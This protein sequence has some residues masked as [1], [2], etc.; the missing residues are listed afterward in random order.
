MSAQNTLLFIAALVCFCTELEAFDQNERSSSAQATSQQAIDA[1]KKCH[2]AS[3]TGHFQQAFPLCQG[4]L[5]LALSAFGPEHPNTISALAELAELYH[6][7]GLYAEAEP[8]YKQALQVREKTLGSEHP[9]VATSLNSL[10]LL[11]NHQRRYEQAEPLIQRALAIRQKALGAEHPDVAAILNNLASLDHDRGLYAEAETLYA[12]ALLIQQQEK[13]V[14]NPLKATILNNLASLYYDQGRYAEAEALY[15]QALTIELKARGELHPNVA[16]GMNYLA[17]VYLAQGRYAQA[18]LF[19]KGALSTWESAMGKEHRNVAGALG[20]LAMLYRHRGQYSEAEPLFKRAI[21]IHEHVLGVDHPSLATSLD[22]LAGLYADQRRFAQAYQLASRA[23]GIRRKTL[24]SEHPDVAASLNNL[25]SIYHDQ[26]QYVQAEQLLTQALLIA[27]KA[28]GT[29]HPQVARTL[30]NVALLDLAQKRFPQALPY[31]LR[32]HQIWEKLIRHTVSEPRVTA[33][34]DQQREEEERLYGL[35]LEHGQDTGL[36][37]LA[38]TLILLRKGRAAEAGAQASRVILDTLST[39]QQHV[40]FQQWQRLRSEH[41][42]L[43]FLGS[44]LHASTSSGDRLN[45]LAMQIDELEHEL[46]AASPRARSLEV[47]NW[48]NALSAVAK[49]LPEASVL[50]EVVLAH[51][52]NFQ[53]MGSAQRWG[54]A[55]YIAM[56]LFPDRRMDTV[57]IGEEEAIDSRVAAFLRQLGDKSP[58]PTSAAQALYQQVM[59]PLQTKL[60]KVK[61]LYLSLDGSLNLIPFSAL[62]DGSQYLID[63][64]QIHYLTSGRDLLWKPLG[65]SGVPLVLADPDYG[66]EVK[67]GAPPRNR[68]IEGP[69]PD[70]YAQLRELRR[71]P[72]TRKEAKAIALLLPEADVRLDAAASE[73]SLRQAQA[74]RILHIATHGLFLADA[75]QDAQ[76][77]NMLSAETR[78]LVPLRS[79]LFSSTIPNANVRMRANRL[80]NPLSRSALI[81]A[82]ATHAER[83]LDSQHDGVLTA[84]EIRSMNLWGT[85]LVVLSACETGRGA[86]KTGQGVYGLR[87]SFFVAGAQTVVT[88]LWEVADSETGELMQRY[89]EKLV[90]E[91]KPRVTALQEAMRELRKKKPHPYYWAPFIVLGHDGPL[92]LRQRK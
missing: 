91:G 14:E 73:E 48:D 26:G 88:S 38:L 70:M 43:L 11:Y 17:S 24:G 6:D 63:S 51:P 59:A 23:L 36:R 4:S 84:E 46:A 29:G 25:A 7:Q 3:Q 15:K 75:P 56:L 20:N 90:R 8:L 85:E 1:S 47:P 61:R 64:Y 41:E 87:R 35:L 16:M 65:G 37:E 42:R 5:K 27:E 53:A 72:A 21:A 60:L 83:G 89:Y 31:L 19:Y 45:M 79:E 92:S 82:G 77:A 34:L 78:A 33:L 68:A 67:R 30:E 52:Y 12:R 49:K 86:V 44:G 9:D 74:P 22:N 39:P 81:L 54:K 66:A 55:H 18:E 50:V 62:F 57:D 69:V 80:T 40:R 2:T 13:S 71:L 10:A 32:A 28:L 58:N 76:D